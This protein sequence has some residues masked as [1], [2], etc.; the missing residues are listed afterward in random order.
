MC[1]LPDAEFSELIKVKVLT[2]LIAS[3]DLVTGPIWD[4]MYAQVLEEGWI[5]KGINYKRFS[6][7]YPSSW[8]SR[9]P[10]THVVAA[11]LF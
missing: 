1:E 11:I 9:F 6:N 3:V 10:G 5:Q 8:E 2:H 7:T 4:I